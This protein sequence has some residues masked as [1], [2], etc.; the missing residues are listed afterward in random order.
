[1]TTPDPALIEVTGLAE[2]DVPASSVDL[3]FQVAGSSLVTGRAA[4]SKAKEVASIVE[5][6]R[7]AG[8]D[9]G[10]VEVTSVRAEVKSGLLGKTSSASYALVLHCT[11]LELVPAALGAITSAKNVAL[12]RLEWRYP[13][14]AHSDGRLL[15]AAAHNAQV[16]AAAIAQALGVPLGP[17]HGAV[18]VSGQLMMGQTTTFGAPM[19][20]RARG[21]AEALDLGVELQHTQHVQREVRVRYRVGS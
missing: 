18:E 14:D 17:L 9:D 7:A 2:A 15:A 1:M 11:D 12:E 19:A 8:F 21:A 6:L 5:A 3:H 13:N 16:K 4:L 20:M 10:A